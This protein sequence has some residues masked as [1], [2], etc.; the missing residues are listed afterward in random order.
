MMTVMCMC[1]EKKRH[2]MV[3]TGYPAKP[4]TSAVTTPAPAAAQ[5]N[6]KNA[7]WEK[8]NHGKAEEPEREFNR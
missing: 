4:L 7:A 1:G 8:N 5:K 2:P 3:R 6:T